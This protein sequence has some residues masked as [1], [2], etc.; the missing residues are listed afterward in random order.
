[1]NSG[2]VGNESEC[3][4]MYYGFAFEGY[5]IVVAFEG[6]AIVFLSKHKQTFPY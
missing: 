4:Y 5:S 6:H 2:G 3:T 1:M